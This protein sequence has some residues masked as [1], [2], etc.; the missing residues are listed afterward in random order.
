MLLL[1]LIFLVALDLA[2]EQQQKSGMRPRLRS[3]LVPVMSCQILSH[4]G[5]DLVRFIII[6]I[7]TIAISEVVFLVSMYPLVAISFQLSQLV[8]NLQFV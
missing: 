2:L 3:S 8:S 7:T 5:F 6:F 4:P 1:L